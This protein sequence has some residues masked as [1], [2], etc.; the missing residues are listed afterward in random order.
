VCPNLPGYLIGVTPIVFD[1]LAGPGLDPFST[2]PL[3][4]TLYR[5]GEM[6]FMRIVEGPSLTQWGLI[7]LTLLLA[8]LGAI[9]VAKRH[10]RV[11]AWPREE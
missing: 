10:R 1:P 9:Q 11:R 8:I 2:T 4:G 3:T 6:R 7:V 5:D